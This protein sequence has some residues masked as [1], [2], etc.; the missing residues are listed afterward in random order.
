MRIQDPRCTKNKRPWLPGPPPPRRQKSINEVAATYQA[1]GHP[2]LNIPVREIE[3]HH[4]HALLKTDMAKTLLFH[5]SHLLNESETL[6]FHGC[7][8]SI[9]PN[10]VQSFSMMGPSIRFARPGGYF[11]TSPAVYW[12]TSFKFALAWCIFTRTGSW[13]TPSGSIPVNF[14]CIIVVAKVHFE[15][16]AQGHKTIFLSC[17]TS[18]QEENSFAS[19]GFYYLIIVLACGELN[20]SSGVRPIHWVQMP[21]KALRL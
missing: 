16:L 10:V 5:T 21:N 18:T 9:T 14:E 3:I 12:T 17:P 7:G 20:N 13:P 15:K 1:E 4:L 19:V 2:H 8:T 11:S 6:L